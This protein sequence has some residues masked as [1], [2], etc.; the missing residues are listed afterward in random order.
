MLRPKQ[1]GLATIEPNHRL[2]VNNLLPRPA[3]KQGWGTSGFNLN[4][5]GEGGGGGEK[6][7]IFFSNSLLISSLQVFF[8]FPV[9]ITSCTDNQLNKQT[10]FCQTCKFVNNYRFSGNF[11]CRKTPAF[12]FRPDDCQHFFEDPKLRAF[13]SLPK[14]PANLPTQKCLHYF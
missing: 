8:A 6:Y 13:F 10:L 1:V 4:S 2:I 3:I 11:S 5:W 7:C 12:F 14:L 9:P